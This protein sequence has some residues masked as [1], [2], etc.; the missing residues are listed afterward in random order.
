MMHRSF[1]VLRSICLRIDHVANVTLGKKNKWMKK[2]A[3]IARKID[4]E[5]K[6]IKLDE[7]GYVAYFEK[8]E[9]VVKQAVGC[10]WKF[11]LPF[12]L[13]SRISCLS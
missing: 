7:I 5:R 6:S 12:L 1:N 11:L 9:S 2:L 8:F 13:T 3:P 4:I 10:C